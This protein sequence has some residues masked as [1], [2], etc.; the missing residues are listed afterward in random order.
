MTMLIF[1]S[2][3]ARFAYQGVF[4]ELS[5][6]PYEPC[7]YLRKDGRIALTLHNA[8]DVQTLAE[9]FQNGE[10]VTAVS[11]RTYTEEAFCRVLEAALESGRGEM[12]FPFA[13][14][15]VKTPEKST[16]PN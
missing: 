9:R 4:Y 15:L 3:R 2:N 16:S 10:T 7:L 12:D 8:F 1:E 14:S 6:H 13:A 5:D 11:G